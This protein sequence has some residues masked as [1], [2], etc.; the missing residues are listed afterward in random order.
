[1]N[2]RVFGVLAGA[3]ML[4][5]CGS[6]QAG[7][8]NVCRVDVPSWGGCTNQ[9]EHAAKSAPGGNPAPAAPAKPEPKPDPKPE[10]EKPTKPEKPGKPD[11]PGYG[12]GDKEHEHE[13]RGSGTR[14]GRNTPGDK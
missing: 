5:G 13:G 2:I 14:D 10:P 12:W 4:A 8:P 6:F 7:M 9:D 3:L 1:M 11:K